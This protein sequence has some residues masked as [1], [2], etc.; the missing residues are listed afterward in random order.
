MRSGVVH[1]QKLLRQASENPRI[2]PDIGKR[3]TAKA[4]A[5]TANQASKLLFLQ[6][7][8]RGRSGA[9]ACIRL[10]VQLRNNPY[11]HGWIG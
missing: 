5:E 4:S 6:S 10:G 3:R 2:F 7:F 9:L 1:R 11:S 8:S